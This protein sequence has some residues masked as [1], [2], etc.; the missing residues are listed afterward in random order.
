MKKQR[1][2]ELFANKIIKNHK[3]IIGIGY[4]LLS[5]G[6]LAKAQPDWNPIMTFLGWMFGYGTLWYSTRCIFPPKKIRSIRYRTFLVFIAIF[7]SSA[8][9]FAW[10]LSD[11]FVG[12][13]I[14]TV[15]LFIAFVLASLFSIFSYFVFVFEDKWHFLCNVV[16]LPFFWIF[17]ESLRFYH[18]FSGLGFDFL[19]WPLAAF[20]YSRQFGS[21]FGW[22]G[23]SYI[24]VWIAIS[25]Y[26]VLLKKQKAWI[27]FLLGIVCPFV[28]GG[29]TYE[30]INYKMGKIS[31]GID[32]IR[33]AV[34]QPSTFKFCNAKASYI[35][36][37][38]RHITEN[39]HRINN[40]PHLIVLPETLIPFEKDRI[41]YSQMF[42]D[43][44]IKIPINDKKVG[45]SNQDLILAMASYCNSFV[46][47]GMEHY[48]YDQGSV[49]NTAELFSQNSWMGRYDKTILVP[50]GEYIPGGYIGNKIFTKLFPINAPIY[51]KS[52]KCKPQ[53]LNVQHL[54]CIGVSICYEETF[55]RLLRHYKKQNVQLLINLSNDG[56]YPQTRLP[57]FH[58]Y[59]GLLRN[60]ELGLPSVRCCQTGV[61]VAL[62]ALGR[63]IDYLPYENHKNKAPSDVLC[64]NVPLF[65]YTTLYSLWGDFPFQILSFIVT[66]ILMFA[67][68]RLLAKKKKE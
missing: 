23:Q 4:Y 19:G 8:F 21:F 54:P 60:Q 40:K 38:W 67:G 18:L 22:M 63:V 66:M 3:V 6:M 7:S 50:G 34:I 49:L 35:N 46:L 10:L 41:I 42:V 57:K 20:A 1:L 29:V 47:V 17:L 65:T 5:L 44:N 26:Y 39:C 36:T 30:Y 55:G 37:T 27:F 64:V 48:N 33:V 15:W 9:H 25:W 16:L 58:F 2:G 31:Q 59:H 11:E 28:I 24:T 14:L 13:Y 52:K 43:E 51:K 61:T 45:W 68:Y 53:A 32:S 62:D 56:W 12:K